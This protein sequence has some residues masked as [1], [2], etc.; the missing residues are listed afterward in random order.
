MT[1]PEILL[2]KSPNG[3]DQYLWDWSL[4]LPTGDSINTVTW[5]ADTG[6][7]VAAVSHTSTSATVGV[8]SGTAGVMYSITCSIATVNGLAEQ[9]SAPVS[10]LNL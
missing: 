10:V 2:E 9:W 3:I 1:S 8:S 4:W 6:I 5:T 7:T